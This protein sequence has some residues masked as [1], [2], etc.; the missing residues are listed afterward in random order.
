MPALAHSAARSV[1][2]PAEVRRLIVTW[3]HPINRSIYPV[4]ILN[5]DGMT[6]T[7]C[8]IQA[9]LSA[10][11]FRPFIGFPDLSHDYQSENLFPLFAQRAMTP[12]RPDFPR[13]VTQ[14]GLPE[15][16]SPWEQ[17][18]R[19]GGRRQGDTIQLFPVP[20]VIGGRLECDFLVH[21][22]RHILER[23]I[24]VGDHQ[25][26]LDRARLEAALN[27]LRPGDPL[28]LCAQ[29]DNP[30]NSRAMLTTT[31]EA[32]PLGWVPD[33]LV[34]VVH[35]LPNPQTTE[36]TVR[37]VNGPEV[38]WHLR[39]LAQLTSR[40]PNDFSAF[41]GPGWQPLAAVSEY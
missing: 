29:P 35:Q 33:L 21:G 12:R 27:S 18:T 2:A 13:W 34:D 25:F 23:T 9:A 36:V 8:Y 4:G 7:F 38:G 14:L 3:Q 39:V 19:S 37:H 10:P 6:Y 30:V 22:I 26:R 1:E 15:D 40:V 41:T 24:L 11:D 20:T 28:A 32:L 31:T 5:F 17:I 16:A